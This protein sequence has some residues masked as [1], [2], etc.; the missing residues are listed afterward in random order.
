MTLVGETWR[1]I[2][3]AA[4]DRHGWV[5]RRL[6]PETQFEI[7]AGR[8]GVDDAEALLFE[9]ASRSIHPS[10]DMPEC[11]GFQLHVEP[12]EAGPGGRSRLCLVLKDRRYLEVFA[13][14]AQD[15][16]NRSLAPGTSPPRYAHS[17]PASSPGSAFSNASV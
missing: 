3:R 11:I 5:V 14:L 12:I 8:R 7:L 1:E 2:R 10:S 13:T 9:V 16:A 15:V 4:T 17:Y 6:F